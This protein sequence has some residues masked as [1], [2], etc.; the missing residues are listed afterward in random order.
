MKNKNLSTLIQPELGLE[1]ESNINFQCRLQAHKDEIIFRYA[2]ET[3]KQAAKIL[4][5]E[6]NEKKNKSARAPHGFKFS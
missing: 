2:E 6:R 1:E 4:T 5:V 3:L